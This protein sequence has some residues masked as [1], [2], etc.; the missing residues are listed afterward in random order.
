M[1]K[2]DPIAVDRKNRIPIRFKR[3]L[4]FF[5]DR[6]GVDGRARSSGARTPTTIC[7]YLSDQKLFKFCSYGGTC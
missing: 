5:L 2:I 4:A 6:A 3:C 1:S 7:A